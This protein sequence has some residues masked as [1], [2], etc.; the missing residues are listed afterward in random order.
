MNFSID[1]S[2]PDTD[3]IKAEKDLIAAEIRRISVRDMI[4]SCAVIV[5]VSVA[6][7][8][9]VYWSTGNTVYAGLAVS[10]FP[11]LG[12]ILSLAG[13]TSV[14]GFRSA[15]NRL[16]ELKNDLIALS[17]VSTDSNKDIENLRSK[18]QRVD[19]YQTNIEKTGRS[20]VNGEL[21][22]YWEFAAS[23][24]AK[25]AR[26]RDLLGRARNALRG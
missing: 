14:I 23:T 8:V 25:T 1:K 26:G 22:M 20:P 19:I 16:S 11:L 3:R 9:I 12:V 17:P 21:A 6:L 24:T 5:T 18:Y 10:L 7:G 4:I 2:P 13:I 15:A